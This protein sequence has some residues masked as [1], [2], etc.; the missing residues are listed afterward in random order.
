MFITK[1]KGMKKSTTMVLLAVAIFGAGLGVGYAASKQPTQAM[2][3]DVAKAQAAHNIADVA[4]AQ[5]G[6]DGSWE[7]IAVGRVFYLG[8]MK[9]EGQTIFDAYL[10]GKQDDS[11]VYRIA[12]VYLEAGDWGKA[13]PIFDAYLERNP[14]EAK[15]LAEVGA[16]YLLNGDRAKAEQLFDRAIKLDPDEVWVTIAMASGYMGVRPQ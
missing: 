5:A 12:R 1:G 10:K 14:E 13:R 7:R 15:D 2:Y 9:A 11:D 6:K 4:M 16:G 3:H 8:G